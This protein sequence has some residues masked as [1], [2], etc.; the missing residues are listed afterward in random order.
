MRAFWVVG[1]QVCKLQG[2]QCLERSPSDEVSVEK[3]LVHKLTYTN[4]ENVFNQGTYAVIPLGTAR[5]RKLSDEQ[6]SDPKVLQ[7]QLCCSP[8]LFSDGRTDSSDA[9]SVLRL[10]EQTAQTDRNP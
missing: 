7:M 9:Q 1:E 8:N 2:K 4:R 3:Q 6:A 5:G 10:G